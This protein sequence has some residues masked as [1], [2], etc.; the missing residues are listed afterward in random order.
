M[1]QCCSTQVESGK[2]NF[3]EIQTTIEKYQNEKV[4]DQKET[5]LN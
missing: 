5:L 1:G 2:Q 4:E 3:N